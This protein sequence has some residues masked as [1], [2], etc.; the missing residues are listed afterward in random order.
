MSEN[1]LKEQHENLVVEASKHSFWVLNERQLCD[2]HLLINNSFA[3]LTNFMGQKDYEAVVNDMHLADGSLWPIPITLGISET[4]A[5]TLSPGKVITLRNGEMLPLAM[6]T[7]SEIWK[8]DMK[9]EAMSVYNTLDTAHPGVDYLLRV[10]EPVYISGSLQTINAPI[11][12][13]YHE[14]RHTPQELKQ[15]LKEKQWNTVVAFQTRNPMHCAHVEMTKFAIEKVN[16]KLLLN[17]VVGI[18]KP[19]DLNYHTRIQCYRNILKYY[20]KDTVFLSLLPL[21]MRMAGPREAV[22]HGLIRKNYGATHF[23]VGRD[24][25]G[26]GN[27]SQGKPFYGPYDAQTL[28]EKYQNEIGINMLTFHEI[29]YFPKQK[30]YF[31]VNT[32]TDTEIF[33]ISGTKLK[34]ML[35][36]DKPIPEWFSYPEVVKEIKRAYPPLKSRGFTIFFTGLSGSGKSTLAHSLI[37][38]LQ[39]LTHRNISLLDGDIVRKNLSS[40]LGFSKE[41]RSLNIRRIG[42]VA[43]EVTKHGGIAICAPIAPYRNDRRA[44]RELI[45]QYGGFI[46]VYLSTPLEVC[47]HRDVKGFYARARQNLTQHFTGI[48]DPYEVPKNPEL[49]LDT[50]TISIQESVEKLIDKVH[51]CGYI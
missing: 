14:L 43:T 47:E 10:S 48:D 9:H 36:Y 41:H 18:T 4:F 20:P 32:Q 51:A 24:H 13:D 22:W 26:P 31:E 19:G 28:F 46:E 45:S 21:A 50:S 7:I 25:A 27:N 34:E 38:R 39:E 42:F 6:L 1:T 5:E 29:A 17:P 8:P 11:H 16:G 15:L 23:I 49:T 44:N 2:F 37:N 3:P 30:K 12:T 35:D 33:T 40:E